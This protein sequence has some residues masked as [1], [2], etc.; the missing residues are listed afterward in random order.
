ML[1]LFLEQKCRLDAGPHARVRSTHLFAAWLGWCQRENVEPG[2]QIAFSRDMTDRGYDKAQDG[3][4]R[5][6]WH[7]IDLYADEDD[8]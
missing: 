7:G 3:N 2:T 6:C 1:G 5:M 8:K 4:G